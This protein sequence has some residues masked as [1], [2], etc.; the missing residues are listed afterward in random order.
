MGAPDILGFPEDPAWL[1]KVNALEN[2]IRETNERIAK[3][4]A[5]GQQLLIDIEQSDAEIKETWNEVARL[6]RKITQIKREIK[7]N[8]I[9]IYLAIAL[10]VVSIALVVFKHR[11]KIW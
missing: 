1:A 11:R 7:N 5:K 9:R 10:I 4:T 3:A 6:E 2:D 8:S